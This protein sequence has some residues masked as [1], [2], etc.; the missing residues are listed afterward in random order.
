MDG[1]VGRTDVEVPNLLLSENLI[2]PFIRRVQGSSHRATLAPGGVGE[3]N[4][5]VFLVVRG[6]RVGGWVGGWVVESF[7]FFLFSLVS[8]LIG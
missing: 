4:A 1:W 8:W 6:A 5:G 7:F 2:R 3:L